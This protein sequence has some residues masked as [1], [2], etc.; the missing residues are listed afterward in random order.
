MDLAIHIPL[1]IIGCLRIICWVV[2]GIAIGAIGL[3]LLV[4]ASVRLPW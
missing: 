1:W 2:I 4:R 3:C